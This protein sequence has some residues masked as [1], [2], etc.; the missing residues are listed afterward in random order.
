MSDY[1][2]EIRLRAKMSSRDA[3][4]L[5]RSLHRDDRIAASHMIDELDL[6]ECA[7][8]AASL[9]RTAAMWAEVVAGIN[10][11]TVDG[12]I[13]KHLTALDLT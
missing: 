13:D 9:A 1:Q 10:G 4:A 12:L 11:D 7:W 5:I 8:V 3:F 6:E 2:D